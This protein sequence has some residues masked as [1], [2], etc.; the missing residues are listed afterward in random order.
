MGKTLHVSV[1]LWGMEINPIQASTEAEQPP[2]LIAALCKGQARVRKDHKCS[3]H[4]LVLLHP[5]AQLSVE[6][7][8][9]TFPFLSLSLSLSLE[10]QCPCVRNGFKTYSNSQMNSFLLST[11]S[12]PLA[13]GTLLY[14]ACP[15]KVAN[16]DSFMTCRW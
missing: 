15:R 3:H 8:T 14:S 16:G 5:R 13:L 1:F 11:S 2:S 7:A 12:H 10:A 6:A 4:L 9:R